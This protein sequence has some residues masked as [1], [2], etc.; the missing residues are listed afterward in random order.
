MKTL[1]T[2]VMATALSTSMATAAPFT[3]ETDDNV[4]FIRCTDNLGGTV[5]CEVIFPDLEVIYSCIAL[6]AEDKPL[7]VTAAISGMLM[8]PNLSASLIADIKCR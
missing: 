2:A 5:F 1:L 8:Y 7:A 6:D 4:L 3:I